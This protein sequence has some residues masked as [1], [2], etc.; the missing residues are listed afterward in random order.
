MEWCPDLDAVH[1]GNAGLR[2]PPSN[3]KAGRGQQ[4][5]ASS[6]PAERQ[7]TE[8]GC[9][10]SWHAALNHMHAPSQKRC[11]HACLLQDVEMEDANAQ[12]AAGATASAEPVVLASL[13]ESRQ[14]KPAPSNIVTCWDGR[15]VGGQ[16][17]QPA[18]MRGDDLRV[19]PIA[20]D[21]HQC[22]KHKAY[23]QKLY[24]C[25]RPAC[26]FCP[27]EGSAAERGDRKVLSAMPEPGN[28]PALPHDVLKG[29]Q[30]GAAR[31]RRQGGRCPCCAVCMLMPIYCGCIV[32]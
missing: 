24:T 4:P 28:C 8:V 19:Q 29:A 7:A 9:I 25:C 3:K 17:Q 6:R 30:P 15:A 22:C 31:A 27:T 21:E 13:A 20:Q 5:D 11:N 12:T 18:R 1:L 2:S 16:A 10:S 32:F 23:W 14:H 26:Q